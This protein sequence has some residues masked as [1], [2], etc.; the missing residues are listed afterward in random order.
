MTAP[1]ARDYRAGAGIPF[2]FD[3]A[4]AR[5]P[6]PSPVSAPPQTRMET[7]S[8][9]QVP[10]LH[11]R[12]RR[13]PRLTR[14]LDAAASQSIVVA[15]PAGYG[16]T[17]LVSEWL[18]RRMDVAWY[19]AT[20]AS[21]DV[22]AFSVGISD[23]LAP[24]VPGVGDRLRQRVRIG[25]TPE[26]S[27]R[28]L[29]ELLAEDLAAWPSGAWLVIDDYH[30]VIDSSPVEEF[31]DWL[32]MLAPD[33]RVIA[34]TRRR[35]AWATAR[36]VLHGE[37]TEL[38]GDRLTMTDEEAAL[39]LEGRPA[40]TIPAIVA[41]AQG[42]P[43]LLGLA[44][45]SS[46]SDIPTERLSGDLFRYFAEEVLRQEP[47]EIQQFMLVASLPQSVGPKIARDLLG[48]DDP[49]PILD[50]LTE[51][52]LLQA[53]SPGE[54]SFHPLL[55]EFLRR[56]LEAEQP[57]IAGALSEKVISNARSA[58]RWEEAFDL[59]MYRQDSTRAAEVIGQASPELLATGRLETLEKW[60]DLCGP[61]ISAHPSSLLAKA[62][63]L[64]CR[65]RI[66]EAAGLALSVAQRIDDTHASS[67]RAWCIA[68]KA[69]HLASD[70][71]KSVNY[72]KRAR[73][74]AKTDVDVIESLWGALLAAVDLEMREASASFLA[75]LQAYSC[76][77]LN[78]QL[79]AAMGVILISQR[80][81]SLEG[82]EEVIAGAL[83]LADYS[84]DPM[85][86]SSFLGSV[87]YVRCLEAR[88]DE[89]MA[90][91]DEAERVCRAARFS[92]GEVLCWVTQAQAAIGLRRFKEASAV[93][94][95]IT[96]AAIDSGDPYLALSSRVVSLKLRLSTGRSTSRL[97]ERGDTSQGATS[98]RGE[99][100]ALLAVVAAVE[101]DSQTVTDQCSRA[102]SLTSGIEATFYSAFAE[103][104]LSLT[105]ENPD[106]NHQLRS[107]MTETVSARMMDALVLG[108]RAYPPLLPCLAREPDH[109]AVLSAVLPRANDTSKGSRAGIQTSIH[110]RRLDLALL[111]HRELEVLRLLSQG[112]TNAEIA[113]RLFIAPSTVK[114]HVHHILRKLGVKTRL[115]AVLR[116]GQE[117]ETV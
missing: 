17:L 38:G 88:Y 82:L 23:V 91:A 34:T 103:A 45:L 68:G 66:S 39:V 111:T 31:M 63:T 59:T 14:L 30:L 108:Y 32:L 41:Q 29:A 1:R 96:R 79:R 28:P 98:L 18:E 114:V 99:F 50:R 94:G 97:A 37:V 107:L 62:T 109:A 105:H 44:A 46:S 27:V 86:K 101:N 21:A 49:E 117:D 2:V 35:P 5:F 13:R 65:G 83:P 67:S 69:M 60:L 9:L 78:T 12:H 113:V 19:R 104:I 106:A 22:A 4:L 89:A 55:R 84:L 6:L 85:I 40:E 52:G 8:T 116:I 70:D 95:R 64:M 16:K 43:A 15:A 54:F 75:E 56:K 58:G 87:A 36:R 80:S 11:R 20:S 72:H 115:Q 73:L 7:R 51:E 92:Y 81:G 26:N 90:I 42:W 33:I 3:V 24:L 102:R 74:A 110:E 53:S 25:D 48:L 71:V 112:L 76:D 47:P 77:D 100:H 57:E 93:L 10:P 61:A